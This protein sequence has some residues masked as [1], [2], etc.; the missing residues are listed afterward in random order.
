[1]FFLHIVI[2]ELRVPNHIFSFLHLNVRFRF[3]KKHFFLFVFITM[4]KKVIC[5]CLFFFMTLDGNKCQGQICVYIL[6]KTEIYKR[7]QRA[8]NLKRVRVCVDFCLCSRLH[9]VQ[10]IWPLLSLSGS[11]RSFLVPDRM[12]PCCCCL[13]PRKMKTVQ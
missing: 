12:S 5:E 8:L 9:R 2:P 3:C 13:L 11:K 6:I 4:L 7:T 10:W 1:M